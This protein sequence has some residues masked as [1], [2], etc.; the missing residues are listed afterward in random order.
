MSTALDGTHYRACNLCEAICGLILTVQDGRVTSVRGDPD[1]PLSRGHICPKGAA[2]PDIH[3]DP[4]RLKRPLRRDGDT[5]TELGWDEALDYVATRLRDV[6][7]QHGQDSVAVYQGNPSVHNSGTMLS[8]GGLWR[9]LG[10]RQRYSATSVDQLPHHYAAWQMFG[11]PLLLPI[12]D[13]DRTH[14]FLILGG[15]PLASNGSIMTAPGM[16]ARLKALRARGGRVVVVDPRRTETA[17]V[18]DLHV[19]IRPGTDALLLLALLHVIFEENLDQGGRTAAFTDGLPELR[20]A[21]APFTPERV[22]DRTG[23]D[24]ATIRNLARDFAAASHAVAYGRMG[25]STQAFGGLCQWLVNALNVVTGNLDREGG[26][27]FPTPAFDTLARVRKGEQVMGRWHTRVRALPEFDGELPVAALAEEIL[28]PG[29]GQVH[30]VITSCGNPVLSTPNG[31]QL[32]RALG[33]LDF[34]VSIDIYLNET[35]RH[36]H[37]ILPPAT[38]LETEHYDVIFHHFAVRNTARFNAPVLP[39]GEDQRFDHQI[40]EGLRTRLAGNDARPAST[41]TER[42]DFGLRHGPYRTSLE[43]LRTHPH[44]I[45]YGPLQPRLPERL[46]TTD[47][48]VHLAPPPLLA[49]L[50]RLEVTLHNDPP[51]LLLIG[52][53]QLRRNNSWMHGVQRLTRGPATCTLQL[54]PHDAA[55]LG[56]HNG[57][58][59]RVASRVGAVTVPAEITDRVMPGVVSLPHGYGPAHGQQSGASANDLTDPD[60][61]D[62][63]TGN[64]VLNGLP[65]QL[66]A[67]APT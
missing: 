29:E 17:D 4:R 50:A 53:R 7:T 44:G 40:F 46:A 67:L 35:T 42:L 20:R 23:V 3:A 43:E 24:A 41:P 64:A 37:V 58:H 61:L 1:D 57:Q 49:D 47:G 31:A 54:H 9:A 36:A 66:T 18:A 59:V 5:W 52:R 60:T 65:V 38:G 32:K 63:L 48:R 8:S 27:M 26:A 21:S 15:N 12:P 2:L 13:V 33:T 10:T 28:T 55:R 30:A 19:P 16:R 51:E 39:I 22:A 34:M 25:V 14:F 6:Q 56:V 62:T 45:D 11:H